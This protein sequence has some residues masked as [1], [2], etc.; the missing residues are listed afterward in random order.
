[1]TTR[2]GRRRSAGRGTADG[3][4]TIADV[5]REAGVSA[6]TVSRTVNGNYPVAAATRERIESAMHSLGY[7]VNA[8]ARA[9][10]G[11]SSRIVGIVVNDV[12]DPFFGYITRGVQQES[13]ERNLLCLVCSS[14]GRP[15]RE[16]AYVELLIQQ[17]ADVVVLVGG[18]YDDADYVAKMARHARS[19]A[20]L[21]S[22]LTLCGRPSLGTD[23]P[24]VSVDYDNEGGAFAA[25]DHLLNAGHR[26]ILYL[27]GPTELSTT[28]HRVAGHRRALEARGITPDPELIRTGAFGRRWG[29]EHLHEAL[30]AGLDFTAVFAANDLLAAGV[31][32]AVREAGLQI[33][34]DLSIIGYDDM[35]VSVELTP[36][37]TTVRVPLE[38]LG[39]SAVRAALDSLREDDPM[40]RSRDKDTLGTHVVVRDSVGPPRN[41][42]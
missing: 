14:Q 19:L 10:A 23:A 5:A 6:A 7:T 3:P 26:R 21:G 15:E 35:P 16:L 29:Q 27:G 2:P 12:V 37:L 31:Y 32:Q 8:H 11:S 20:S 38:E 24:V 9:L 36:A 25:T 28:R 41:A 40:V 30:D 17:R 1:M 42:G 18:S 13:A 39:R 22:V 34:Q 33:P 4:V